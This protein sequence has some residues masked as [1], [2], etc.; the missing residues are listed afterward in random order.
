MVF[1]L[2]SAALLTTAASGGFAN[3]ADV[4]LLAE[5]EQ[6]GEKNGAS[7]SH[8]FAAFQIAFRNWPKRNSSSSTWEKRRR[9]L[10]VHRRVDLAIA[11]PPQKHS[12]RREQR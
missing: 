12:I 4:L 11:F 8:F 3:G 1:P 10:E 5:K 7:D 6:A 9:V 2:V